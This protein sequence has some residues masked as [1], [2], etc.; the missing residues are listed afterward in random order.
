MNTTL[1]H[2]KIRKSTEKFIVITNF[3]AKNQWSQQMI[4]S[5]SQTLR[6]QFLTQ[7]YVWDVQSKILIQKLHFSI[8]GLHMFWWIFVTPSHVVQNFKKSWNFQVQMSNFWNF[9]KS[10]KS[11]SL[12]KVSRRIFVMTKFFGL[13]P[14]IG[15]IVSR[16]LH[17]KKLVICRKCFTEKWMKSSE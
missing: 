7:I 6:K 12:I 14:A 13:A 4:Q 17:V 11:W 1:F 10:K 3:L 9:S 15:H 2:W 8:F 5:I 16:Y